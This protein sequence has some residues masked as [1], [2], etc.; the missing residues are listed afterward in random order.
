MKRFFLFG[1]ISIFCINCIC[2]QVS[3]SP[4]V[5]LNYR[6]YN[7][8]GFI[9]NPYYHKQPEPYISIMG[10]LM[11]TP[12]TFIQSRIGYIF[13]KDIELSGQSSWDKTYLGMKYINNDMNCSITVLSS[14][15]HNFR[16]GLGAGFVYKLNSSLA[17]V[18]TDGNWDIP[19]QSY[20]YNAH[21][22]ADYKIKDIYVVAAY[23]FFFNKEL[24]VESI[25]ME[26]G[27]YAV[28][29]GVGYQLF[30]GKSKK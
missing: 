24:R 12:K 7:F 15:Y 6:P 3:L 11:L 2:S 27:N 19:I 1:F 26:K 5:G 9:Y 28:S 23:E 10:E 20:L 22:R 16:L 30:K 14:V 21:V 25:R 8:P 29:L 18:Y 13:R 4:E 17:D